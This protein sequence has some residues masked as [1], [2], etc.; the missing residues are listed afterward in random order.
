MNEI[1]A[2]AKRKIIFLVVTIAIII[3]SSGVFSF[4]SVR[5][6]F[7]VREFLEIGDQ[8]GVT[9]NSIRAFSGKVEE[10]K[11]M[12]TI[13]ANI[14][15]T[16]AQTLRETLF[17]ELEGMG[18][19]VTDIS[20]RERA[21]GGDRRSGV[22]EVVV[23]GTTPFKS[24]PDFMKSV[25]S[26]PKIWGIELLE[27]NPRVSPAELVSQFIMLHKRGDKRG[28]ELFLQQGKDFLSN[29]ASSVVD[30]KMKFVVVGG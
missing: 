11:R 19:A 3:A 28:V 7:M 15:Y 1:I 23:S 16:N 5:G 10:A 4:Y 29:E 25:S 26:R 13:L 20:L 8:M 18:L 2:A 24:I 6:G 27:L 9:E 17:R 14:K 21:D 30:V 22:I 12:G